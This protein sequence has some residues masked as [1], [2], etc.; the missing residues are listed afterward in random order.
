MYHILASDVKWYLPQ[1]RNLATLPPHGKAESCRASRDSEYSGHP[2][3][4]DLSSENGGCRRTPDREG[5]YLGV[6]R[7][8]DS[9][10]GK[11]GITAEGEIIGQ[12][13]PATA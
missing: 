13:W 11:E 4:H 7:G 3:G 8:A 10:T 1:S 12:G 6:D 9:G 2:E 5:I